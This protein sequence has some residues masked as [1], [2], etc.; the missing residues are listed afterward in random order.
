MIGRL[1]RGSRY[2]SHNFT[3]LNSAKG[4]D[5][6]P[7]HSPNSEYHI[8]TEANTMTTG[9]KLV[10]GLSYGQDILTCVSRCTAET[11]KHVLLRICDPNHQ[12]KYLKKKL[13]IYEGHTLV[14]ILSMIQQKQRQEDGRGTFLLPVEAKNQSPPPS[15]RDN[16]RR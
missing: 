10:N 9:I 13:S 5:L 6:P 3:S 16:L 7:T 8:T 11:S 4:H 2:I 1:F 12:W 14:L 15:Q